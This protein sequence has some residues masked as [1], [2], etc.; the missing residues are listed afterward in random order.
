[1]NIKHILAYAKAVV[2]LS[3]C[4][5]TI[6]PGLP[7]V[8]VRNAAQAVDAALTYLRNQ[9]VLK[10]PDVNIRWQEKT[11][12]S[13]GPPDLTTTSKLFTSDDWATEVSQGVA[14]LS[15]TVYQITL[16]S[17]KL[18]WHWKGS[19]KAD[20]DVTEV[21]ALRLL[22]EEESQKMEEELLRKSQI[23]PPKPGGYGH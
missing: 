1:M 9:K 20:S 5:F 10:I 6:Q 11:L 2:M 18:H 13:L 15:S 23:Y 16:F 22:S 19:V 3:V 21:S 12:Y 4:T 8:K 17:A 14:P 7:S